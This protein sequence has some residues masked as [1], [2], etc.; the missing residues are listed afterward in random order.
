[1]PPELI[2][3]VPPVPDGESVSFG[4]EFEPHAALAMSAS[5]HPAPKIV[6]L[7]MSSKQ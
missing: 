2:V 7:S 4:A 6:F 1:M 5:A 3:L